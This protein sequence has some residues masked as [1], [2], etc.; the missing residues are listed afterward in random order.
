MSSRIQT[1]SGGSKTGA[2]TVVTKSNGYTVQPSDLG[3]FFNL[4]TSS[5]TFALVLPPATAGFWIR[6]AD[7][8]G[9]FSNNP[10][11][12]EPATGSVLIE[13][14][15]GGRPFQTAWGGW[16]VYS[17]GTSWFVE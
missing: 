13:G 16:L 17:D 3:T 11:T 9:Y 8:T 12:L 6:F 5:T 4:D 15:A 10:M 1:T 14:V 7:S 2:V